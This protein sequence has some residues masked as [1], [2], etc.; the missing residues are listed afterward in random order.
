MDKDT[1]SKWILTILAFEILIPVT[2]IIALMW[3]N[4]EAVHTSRILTLVFILAA[5]LAG[6]L[7]HA[8]MHEIGHV[9]FG[10]TSGYRFM[11][12]SV[13]GLWILRTGGGTKLR[14]FPIAGAGGG[15]I[16]LPEDGYK[17]DTPYTMFLMGGAAM[18][19]LV[20]V[21]FAAILFIDLS[22]AMNYF[23]AMV[24]AL[25]VYFIAANLIPITYRTL[26]N[27]AEML[28][29]FKNDE[30]TKHCAFFAFRM[31]HLLL[32]GGDTTEY[33]NSAAPADLPRGN[34]VAE[35]VRMMLIETETKQRR[36]D[37]A[38]Q[39]S[40]D[41][42]N[43]VESTSIISDMTKLILIFV[44]AVNGEDRSRIDE[45][46]DEKMKKFVRSVS[47]NNTGAMLFLA[48]YEK[49]FGTGGTDINKIVRRFNKQAKRFKEAMSFEKEMMESIL[50]WDNTGSIVQ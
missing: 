23:A 17:D 42:L 28:R 14:F 25:G 41:L 27:D 50:S 9:I 15:T 40:Y 18:N 46:Y 10:R 5:I 21:S 19:I 44:Y 32:T 8:V 12:M 13:F 2:A 35:L 45:I 31:S 49:R 39:M 29:L 43:D 6:L 26:V 1:R 37:R 30:A 4:D 3:V 22:P 36:F 48:A 11:G 7:I 24:A 16:S 33:A 20:T 34:R 38:A 47:V